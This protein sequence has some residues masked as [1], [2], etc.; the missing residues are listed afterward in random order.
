[1]SDCPGLTSGSS[2]TD[3]DS[4]IEL[5]GHVGQIERKKDIVPLGLHGKIIFKAAAIDG[6]P[7]RPVGQSHAGDGGLP[8]PCSQKIVRFRHIF[9]QI[10]N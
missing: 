10:L 9:G 3:V 7:A 6:D 5:A 8:T 1:M 2:A 4:N